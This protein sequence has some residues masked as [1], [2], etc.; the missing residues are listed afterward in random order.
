MPVREHPTL[1]GGVGGKA[2]AGNKIGGEQVRHALLAS[3]DLDQLGVLPITPCHREPQVG[4]G[5]VESR[6]MAVAL[7]VRQDTVAVE[8]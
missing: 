3:T 2:C 1:F 5:L 4:E 7:S 8:H 6:Q